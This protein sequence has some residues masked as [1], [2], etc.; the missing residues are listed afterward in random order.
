MRGKD[1][2]VTL[3]LSTST[4]R[5]TLITMV[6]EGP[7]KFELAKIDYIFKSKNVTLSV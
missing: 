5:I 4:M 2:H 6:I 3:D 7:E 1:R